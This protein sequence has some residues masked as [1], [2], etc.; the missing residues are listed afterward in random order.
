MEER[1]GLLL[2]IL[3][4]AA[5][6]CDARQQP[7]PGLNR[8]SDVCARCED[9]T[10]EALH[11]LNDKSIQTGIIDDLHNICSQI[12]SFK[13]LCIEIVDHYTSSFFSEIASV[14][15][16]ELCEQLNL[17]ESAIFSSQVQGNSC[18]FC[19]NTVSVLLFKLNDHESKVEMME[20]LLKVCNSNSME[21]F[22]KECK[23]V[24]FKYVFL[25]ILAAEDL[26][27]TEDICT[28]LHACPAS[29]AVSKEAST[30][31]EASLLSDS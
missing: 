3:L 30:L 8:K 9:Y 29:T 28:V 6:A 10:T 12:L 5:W 18:G 22:A 20:A 23:T 31:E 13:Q 21:K 25:F 24:V 2:L 7:N 11:Y 16:G 17:C 4:G 15:P 26:M 27:K 19:K 1:M 14:Q